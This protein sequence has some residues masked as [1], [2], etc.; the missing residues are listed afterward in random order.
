MALDVAVR[1]KSHTGLLLESTRAREPPGPLGRSVA[2]KR[3]VV[4]AVML[5]V[6][7]GCS[8]KPA[9]APENEGAQPAASRAMIEGGIAQ[10]PGAPA[11]PPPVQ[12]VSSSAAPGPVAVPTERKV[13]RNGSLTVVVRALDEALSA[14]RSA[15]EKAGGYVT[16][17]SQDRD[18]WGVRHGSITCRVPAAA[19]DRTLAQFQ[20]LGKVERVSVTAE[21]ITEQY[22]N[23]E[24][25]L[26][27]QQDLEKRFRALLDRPGNKVSDLLEIE[28]QMARVRGEID[29][30][31]GRKRFW[32]SQVSLSTLT[33]QLH[34]PNP[35]IGSAGGGILSTLKNAI[36]QLGENFVETVAW[37]IS[38]LG[39]VI[40]AG[41]ALWIASLALR[42][43]RRRRGRPR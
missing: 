42:A 2:V 33:V 12:G 1:S 22:F 19:L 41:L 40:P 10:A 3:T 31:E 26:R 28:G 11:P 5:L 18:T 9:P 16:N 4:L 29:E 14:I 34:E 8:N 24:I 39:V 32:D 6:V 43:F 30:L 20:S 17:E 36:R 25:R 13:I 15:T 27:N 21:D 37:L 7:V 23:L 35:A 38:A